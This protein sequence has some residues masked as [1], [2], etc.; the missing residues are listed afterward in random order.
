MF[1]PLRVKGIRDQFHG[2]L[3]AQS[4]SAGDPERW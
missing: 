4:Y 3:P 1:D 2:L